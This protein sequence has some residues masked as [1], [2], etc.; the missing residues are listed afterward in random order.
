MYTNNGLSGDWGATLPEHKA[1]GVE[2]G[3]DLFAQLGI[4]DKVCIYIYAYI[5]IYIY[6]HS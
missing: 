3:Y 4:A 6:I 2:E 5:Y 1:F